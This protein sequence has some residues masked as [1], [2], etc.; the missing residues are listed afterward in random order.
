MNPAHSG[1]HVILRTEIRSWRVML[2]FTIG[3][4]N[5]PRVAVEALNPLVVGETPGS[6]TENVG[7]FWR[8]STSQPPWA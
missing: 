1:A 7:T 6:F 5:E 8:T 4:G 2:T 3:R